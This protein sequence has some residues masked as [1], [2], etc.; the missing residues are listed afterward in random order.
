MPPNPV[1]YASLISGIAD[2]E[3]GPDQLNSAAFIRHIDYRTND[4]RWTLLPKASKESGAVVTDLSL[5]G[6]RVGDNTYVYGD[7]GNIY[8]RTLAGAVTLLNNTPSSSGNGLRYFGEDDFLYYTTDTVIGRY[9]LISGTPGFVD[10]FLGAQGGVPTNTHSLDLELG[11]SQYATAADSATLSIVGDLTL[12]TWRKPESLP[13]AGNE[14][15]LISKW[16]KNSDERSYKW[17]ITHAAASSMKILVIG[18]GGAGGG[19]TANATD[20]AGGGGGAGGFIY[21]AAFTV[22]AQAYTVTVGGAGAGVS[23]ASGGDGSNSVF[24]TQTA[25]GG[26]GGGGN[27]GVGRAGGSGGGGA[28]KGSAA[29]GAASG[30]G[31]GNAGAAGNAAGG[32]AGGGGGA[33]AAGS[34]VSGGAGTAN[35]ISGSAVTY[36]VGADGGSGG[37]GTGDDGTT[38]GSGGGGRNR[39]GGAAA[40]DAGKAGVVA[41]SYVTADF[42][43]CTGGTITTD[44]VNTVHTFTSS[45]TFTVVDSATPYRSRLTISS[46]GTNEEVYDNF[47]TEIVA[48]SWIHLG[49]KLDVSESTATFYES[50][51]NIG[52]DTG[53]LT[54]IYDGTALLAIGASFSAAGAAENFFDGLTDENRIFSDLRSDSEILLNKDKELL[55]T[56]PNL[57]AYYQHDNSTGDSS[58]NSN[59]LTLVATPVYSTDVPFAGATTRQDIDQSSTAIGDVYTLH[60]A[61]DEGAT[62]R[63]TFVPAKDPQKSISV[64]VSTIGTGTWTL[65]V[66]DAQNRLIASKAIAVGDRPTA[67]ELE[68]TFAAPWTPII[69]A[70]YHFHLISTV[71]DGVIVADTTEDLEVGQFYSYYQFLVT[72][73]DYHPIEQILNTLAFGNGRYLAT[74]D[75]GTY[76]PHRLTF[77]SGWRVRCLDFWREYIAIG[78]WRGDSV[79]AYDQGVIFFWDGTSDTYNFYIKVPQGAVNAMLGSGETLNIIAGYEGALLEYTGGRK[80]RKIKSL[81][82]LGRGEQVE[83]LP[84]AFSMWKALLRIGIGVTDSETLE[85]GVYTWG[86]LTEKQP[87]SLSFDY[88]ISTLNTQASNIK[89]GLVLPVEK[90]LLIGWKDDLSHGLD[91]VDPAGTSFADGSVEYLISDEGGIWKEKQAVV[92]RAD[93]EAL[94]AGESVGLQHK[95]DR[96]SAWTTET[97]EDTDDETKLREPVDDSRHKE[98]QIKLNMYPGTA[99]SPAVLGVT[100]DENLLTEEEIV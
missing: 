52:T 63:Q 32:D 13:T 22:A 11:S 95:L 19:A 86:A 50:G 35:S 92:F 55:G 39:D 97:L 17:V 10:D 60:T 37:T 87:D 25:G 47:L 70:T 80:V 94:A 2:F 28:E 29:G 38:A 20:K 96:A 23:G 4:R 7:G 26:G 100:L 93:F 15:V 73:A 21:N 27:G 69:G 68:F 8:K 18:G 91:S 88:A 89:I 74:W 49:V 65:T 77:P 71:A 98:Y 46:N 31:T 6:E 42:G 30:V 14:M 1:S 58:V 40:G 78:C 66:H 64:F 33:G 36:A 72:D 9:G 44:G 59:T 51:V 3:K 84:G 61:I 56:D 85:Q 34:G 99:T 62:H 75:G 54:S 24:S 90:K 12:E 79:E 83:V 16:N 5:W 43:A 67:G 53:A 48:G 45:G 57:N 81:A 76:D 41:I 82:K